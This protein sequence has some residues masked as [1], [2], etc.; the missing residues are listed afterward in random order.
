MVIYVLSSQWCMLKSCSY[1]FVIRLPPCISSIVCRKWGL[2]GYPE[3]TNGYRDERTISVWNSRPSINDED[4]RK[5]VLFLTN[6]SLNLHLHMTCIWNHCCRV[7]VSV[8][9]ICIS[10]VVVSLLYIYSM[11]FDEHKVNYFSI[12]R[13]PLLLHM[14]VCGYCGMFIFSHTVVCG[15][16]LNYSLLCIISM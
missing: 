9:Y 16:P 15:D 12:K 3:G 4:E 7:Y 2:T 5:W 8:Q 14:G 6:N 13:V 11:D 1:C 10:S